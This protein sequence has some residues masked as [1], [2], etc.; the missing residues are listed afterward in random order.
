MSSF[1]KFLYGTA[2]LSGLIGLTTL[3][4]VGYY[5]WTHPGVKPLACQTWLEEVVRPEAFSAVILK[6]EPVDS[7]H[8]RIEMAHE[9]PGSIEF[10]PCAR[11]AGSI[12]SLQPGDTLTK[13]AGSTTLTLIRPQ[14]GGVYTFDFPCCD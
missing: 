1:R 5:Q 10:C 9:L 11:P 8:F 7:C 14:G 4:V 12:P 3:G 6:V 13:A 2:L